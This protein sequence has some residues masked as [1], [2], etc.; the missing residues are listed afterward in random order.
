MTCLFCR[1]VA[2]DISAKKIFENE[3]FIA[4]HDLYP[5]APIHLL[6]I[7]KKHIDSLAHL[8]P[9]DAPLMGELTLLLPKLAQDFNLKDGFKIAVN[10]GSGGGQ[11]VFHLHYHLMGNPADKA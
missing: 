1:I 9:E 6:V 11:E 7:P 5:K 8:T 2:G 10:T 3:H 4:F